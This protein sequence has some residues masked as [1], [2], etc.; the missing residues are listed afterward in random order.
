MVHSYSLDFPDYGTIGNFRD[1]LTLSEE[2]E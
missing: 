2:N 1:I